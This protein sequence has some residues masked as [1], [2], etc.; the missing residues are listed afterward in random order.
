MR[1]FISSIILGWF[2]LLPLS[3]QSFGIE[4]DSVLHVYP[5]LNE[6]TEHSIVFPNLTNDSLLMHWR[7]AEDNML[8]GW[9]YFLCDLGECYSAIPINATMDTAFGETIPYLEITFNPNEVTGTG[10][11]IFYVNDV[12]FPEVK[13]RIEFIF[14]IGTSAS[15]QFEN[16][17]LQL[18][19][20]PSSGILYSNEAAVILTEL[21]IYSSKG[22]LM[23]NIKKAYL[24]LDLSELKNGSYILT[25]NENGRS[26]KKFIYIIH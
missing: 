19:P 2:Y 20:N 12:N 17:T 21:K 11:L 15:H 18:F 10:N 22:I 16:E 5:P 14:N 8:E 9:D 24:P 13:Q 26:I 4:P 1:V 3:A 25:A 6:Y 23:Q 7:L